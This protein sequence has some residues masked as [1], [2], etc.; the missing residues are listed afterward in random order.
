MKINHNCDAI[1][2]GVYLQSYLLIVVNVIIF[3]FLKF[4]AEEYIIPAIL[5]CVFPPPTESS[6]D[7]NTTSVGIEQGTT[8]KESILAKV[9][10]ALRDPPTLFIYFQACSAFV[11]FILACFTTFLHK[12]GTQWDQYQNFYGLLLNSNVLTFF[13][14]GI[15]FSITDGTEVDEKVS[16]ESI[17]FARKKASGRTTWLVF[18]II[19][20]FLPPFLT[21]ILPAIVVYCWIWM[22]GVV[23]AM[24]VVCCFAFLPGGGRK[25]GEKE[26][27]VDKL[28]G[29]AVLV[30]FRLLIILVFQTFF[31]YMYLL[32]QVEYKTVMSS[33]QYLGVITDEYALRTQTSCLFNHFEGSLKNGLVLFSWL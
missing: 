14:S 16:R 23:I 30:G 27:A 9:P 25:A 15:I 6:T 28:V 11:S 19:L 18:S 4:I 26:T 22:A 10:V 5:F 32:Y 24:T 13:V 1:Y 29:M 7:V 17:I 21:H 31:N 20:L 8:D 33:D 12:N 3:T 2:G